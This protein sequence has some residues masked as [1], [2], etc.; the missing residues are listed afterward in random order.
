[1]KDYNALRL[2]KIAN[3]WQISIELMVPKFVSETKNKISLIFW[4]FGYSTLH[5]IYYSCIYIIV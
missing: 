3:N 1:M 4:P 5:G 2:D